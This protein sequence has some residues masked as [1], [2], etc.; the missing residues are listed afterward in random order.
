MHEEDTTSWTPP[1]KGSRTIFDK[2][3]SAETADGG[4]YREIREVSARFERD[5]N[6]FADESVVILDVRVQRVSVPGSTSTSFRE[7]HEGV[8]WEPDRTD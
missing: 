8:R 2:V 3:Q 7:S 4:S 1:R 6:G 5:P